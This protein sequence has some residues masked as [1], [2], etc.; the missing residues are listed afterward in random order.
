MGARLLVAVAGLL[1]AAFVGSGF[2]IVPGPRQTR[3]CKGLNAC[4]GVRGLW[5]VVPA[6]GQATYLLGCPLRSK[7]N[8]LFLLG[9]TDSRVSSSHVHVWYEGKLGAPIGKQVPGKPSSGLLFHASTDNGRQGFF[10][11][12][13]GCISLKQALKRSTLSATAAGPPVGRGR[14]GPPQPT[15]RTQSVALEPGWTRTIAAAC[16]PHESLVGGWSAL[17]FGTAGPPIAYREGSVTLQNSRVGRAARTVV[18]TAASV[19]YL[20]HVQVGAMCER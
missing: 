11:P 8:G 18:H 2:V 19:P 9:G 1:V 17:A 7:E 16:P 5:V 12:V 15:Y 4:Y 3:E 20:I 14:L 13:V 6:H 10:Q